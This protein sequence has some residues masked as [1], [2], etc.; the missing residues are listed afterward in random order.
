MVNT[1]DYICPVCGS[2][3]RYCDMVKRII[4]T[5]KRITK[6]IKIERRRC[7]NDECKSIH[8]VLPDYILPYKQYEKEVIDGVI[9]GH[10]TPGTLGYEDYPCEDTMHQWIS[11]KS[12]GLL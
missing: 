6:F 7:I 9:E 12:Q 8:R 2:E 10:I 3:L 1:N 11:Q 4:R 5:K